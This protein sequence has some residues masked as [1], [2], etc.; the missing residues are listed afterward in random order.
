MVL[1]MKKSPAK[2]ATCPV[3]SRK[4]AP[5][6]LKGHLRI[7]HGSSEPEE[8]E[9]EIQRSSDPPQEDRRSSRGGLTSGEGGLFE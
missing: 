4:F 6:G 1:R 8:P 7:A 3:C 2:T 9:R 5:Q